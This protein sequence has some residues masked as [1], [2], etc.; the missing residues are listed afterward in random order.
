MSNLSDLTPGTWNVDPSHSG[1]NFS[2]KHLMVSKVRGR[3]GSF[4]GSLEIAADPLQS[5][6]TASADVDSISTGDQG[7][8]DH[9]KSA[10]FFDAANFPTIEF[11]ST[12]IEADGD[13]FVLFADL[14]IRGITKNVKFELEFEGIGKDPW[15]NIK[16]GFTAD[17]EINRKDW[18]LEWNAALETGGVLVGEKVK[19]QLDIQ[20]VKS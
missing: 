1:L 18:G 17:A 19:L 3:F 20:A 4:N 12:K 7:R 15:G 9:L 10:D 2:V 6:V 13:D 14:T 16:A 5:T 8:D 11:K